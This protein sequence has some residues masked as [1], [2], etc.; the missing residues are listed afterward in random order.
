[1]A[2]LDVNEYGWVTGGV[3]AFPI[4]V[5]DHDWLT[6]YPRFHSIPAFRWEAGTSRVVSMFVGAGVKGLGCTPLNFAEVGNS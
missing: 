2:D 3:E 1:M 5:T 6:P 4:H